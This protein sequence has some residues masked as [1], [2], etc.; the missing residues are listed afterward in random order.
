MPPRSSASAVEVVSR[1][2]RSVNVD[3]SV[4]TNCNVSTFVLS[5]VG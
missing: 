3:P 2:C 5:A 1:L 4:T